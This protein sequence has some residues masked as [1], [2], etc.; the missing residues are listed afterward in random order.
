MR[1]DTD[2]ERKATTHYTGAVLVDDLIRFSEERANVLTPGEVR[3]RTAKDYQR[4]ALEELAD[5]RNYLVWWLQAIH[6][7]EVGG[8]VEALGDAMRALAVLWRAVREAGD[9][10]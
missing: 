6:L 3:D 4:E 2:F 8:G 10:S 1:R 7:E 5:C 9:V